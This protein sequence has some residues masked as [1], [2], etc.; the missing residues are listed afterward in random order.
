[1]I[2]ESMHMARL[3]ETP[4]AGLVTEI[5]VAEGHTPVAVGGL[6]TRRHF[7]ILVMPQ[8]ARAVGA[9]PSGIQHASA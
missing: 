7:L 5:L 1:M 6:R 8:N 3:L 9:R 4:G 2:L